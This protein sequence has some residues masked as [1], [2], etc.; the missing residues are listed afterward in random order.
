[1][2][3]RVDERATVK[4]LLQSPFLQRA[5]AEG[6]VPCTAGAGTEVASVVTD[7]GASGRATKED[8]DLPKLTSLVQSLQDDELTVAA[9]KIVS[10]IVAEATYEPHPSFHCKL[11]HNIFLAIVVQSSR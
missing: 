10:S 1:M 6:V 8:A 9:L 11:F 2:V 3:R 7:G 4:E 5:A